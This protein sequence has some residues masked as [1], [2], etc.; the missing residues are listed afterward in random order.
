M[1]GN[2]MKI[3]I[4]EDDLNRHEQFKR[5]FSYTDSGKVGLTIVTTAREAIDLLQS[6]KKWEIL[7]LDHDLGG[8]TMVESGPGTGYEV[9]VWLETHPKKMP[10]HVIVHSFNPA[11]AD[12]M[13][14]ALK[15]AVKI[16][17]VWCHKLDE[18]VAVVEKQRNKMMLEKAEKDG[19][20]KRLKLKEE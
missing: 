20:L 10:K 8:K 11:G 13:M 15:G 17:G 18:V 9:A 14:Q 3:L 19:E 5:N 16:P 2:A 4:L 7:C 6:R 12:K 1:D